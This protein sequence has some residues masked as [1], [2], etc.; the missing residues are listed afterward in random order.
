M[1]MNVM[2][3]QYHKKFLEEI[4]EHEKFMSKYEGENMDHV[5]PNLTEGEKERILVTHDECIFYS[6]DGK[7]GIWAKYG[8]MPLRKKRLWKINIS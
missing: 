3:F 7:R 5:Q 4:F 6:N 8:E 1:V 2:M